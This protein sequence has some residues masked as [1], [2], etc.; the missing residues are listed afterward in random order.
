VLRLPESP[1]AQLPGLLDVPV[2]LRHEPVDRVESALAAQPVQ[3]L[4]AQLAA[5]EIVVAIE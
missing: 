1:P 5:I 3:E 4:D 2:H